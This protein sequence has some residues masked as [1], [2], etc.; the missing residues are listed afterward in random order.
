MFFSAGCPALAPADPDSLARRIRSEIRL[1]R[2]NEARDLADRGFQAWR[3]QPASG[4]YWQY[5]ILTAEILLLRGEARN[6]LPLLEGNAAAVAPFRELAIR[7]LLL[8]GHAGLLLG[9]YPKALQ[10]LDEG[11]A[12]AQQSGLAGLAAE[13]AMRKGA[14]L[15]RMGDANA[16]DLSFR[17]ASDLAAAE[18]DLYLQASAIGNL[19]YNLLNGSRFD[20]AA[21]Y[22]E[23]SLA[24]SDRIGARALSTTSLG[25]L[26]RCYYGLGDFD[27]AIQL[28]QKAAAL[29]TELG[30]DQGRQLWLGDLG[31]AYSSQG[32][33]PKAIAHFQQALAISRKIHE[34]YSTVF[35]LCSLADAGISSR[36]PASARK[37]NDEAAA[38]ATRIKAPALETWASLNA[39]LILL[40]V[41]DFRAAEARFRSVIVA[42]SDL[43]DKQNLWAAHSGLAQL[44]A[45]QQKWKE[46]DAEFQ[47]ALATIERAR[48]RLSRDDWRLSLPA[49]SIQAY[50]DYIDFLVDRNQPERALEIAEFARARVL[51]QKL[52]IEQTIEKPVPAL[53]FRAAARAYRAA[54]VSFWL[55]PRRSFVWI[56][57]AD[58]VRCVP[59]P[60]KEEI[61]PLI[62]SY[63]AAVQ[64]LRDPLETNNAAGRRLSE[65]LLKPLRDALPTPARIVLVPDGPLH[66]FNLE[67]LPVDG[68]RPHYWLEDVTLAIAP[69]LAVLGSGS[70]RR[71][72]SSKSLLFIGN[73]Q[74]PGNTYAPLPATEKE[75]AGIRQRLRGWQQTIYAGAAA[76]PGV[77]REAN[78][79]RFSLIH[80]AAHATANRQDPLDSAVVLSPK[81]ESYKL[82]ARDIASIPLEAQ[83]VTISAC[84]G[85]GSRVYSGEGL[86]GFSWAFLQAGAS[87]V[88]A[89]LWE[90]NDYSTA[91]LMDT[92][93][94]GLA[95]GRPPAEALHEAK[96]ALLHSGSAWAKPFYWAPFENLSRSRPF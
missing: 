28:Q 18:R 74:P 64:A 65:M 32:Q 13:I 96:L 59:L 60:G 12:M 16:A 7:R 35:W 61:A 3:N 45:Q 6:A 67:M 11:A 77:Y 48:S 40:A 80:F 24:I 57:T 38:T 79:G 83:L 41:R 20:E 91:A 19:G 82:Y 46:A 54:L 76:Q 94:A 49:R 2:L 39:A 22:F 71:T 27:R 68:P 37:Y 75:L 29:A 55:A 43:Q 95:A 66:D 81:G 8:K 87:N 53:R 92:L 42:S 51:A 10:V 5:R 4:P 17:N 9:D 84:R 44:F 34:P 72:E 89:G 63:Q 86:V 50:Q 88:I 30:D 31:D 23:R 21:P 78:P 70:G 14:V 90:V 73:S 1:G 36:D 52:G 33:F 58:R 26:G 56:V 62:E 15:A 47:A 93:Y 25:N 85:A 69:S